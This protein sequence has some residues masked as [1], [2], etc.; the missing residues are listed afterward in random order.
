MNQPPTIIVI[1]A[2]MRSQRL[3]D[4]PLAKIGG[5]P[6]IVQVWRRACEAEIGPV[7]VACAE[8]EIAEAVEAHGGEAIL[9]DPDLPSGTDRILQALTRFDPERRYG[10]VINLQGDLPSLGP[11]PIRAALD[12][13]R[14]LG[15]D[16]GTLAT[17]IV[18]PAE[19]TNP[20]TVKAVIAFDR[21]HPRL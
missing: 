1:P 19:R 7:L 3:P 8:K 15:T 17:P 11:E 9:T 2:R 16:I 21:Q 18:D 4:K 5:L 13:I 12:P 20:N 14:V 10:D 6:M